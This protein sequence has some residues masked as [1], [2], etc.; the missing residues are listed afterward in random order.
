MK[1]IYNLKNT[2]CLLLLIISSLAVKS[3]TT[4]VTFGQIAS[5]T[6]QTY[7]AGTM[8]DGTT[9]R[10]SIRSNGGDAQTLTAA[11]DGY[12]TTTG[13]SKLASTSNLGS[14]LEGGK[15]YVKCTAKSGETIQLYFYA[16][17]TGSG[18]INVSDSVTSTLKSGIAFT[19]ATTK[20]LYSVT[21]TATS[22]GTFYFSSAS[23]SIY[24][25][26]IV[27]SGTTTT[28][29]LAPTPTSV[30]SLYYNT[31][32]ATDNTGGNP[33]MGQ[34]T[35]KGKN[36]TTA[37]TATITAPT[38]FQISL[39]GTGGWGTTATVSPTADSINKVIYVRIDPT[40]T[41]VGT[42]S[43]NITFSQ[44]DVASITSVA[45]S[46]QVV[47]LTPISCPGTMTVSSITYS[48]A[49]F[50][51]TNV[52]GNNGYIV[53]VYKG[54]VLVGSAQTLA[55]NT[56]TYSIAGL[57]Q[58]TAYTVTVTVIGNGS[59]SGNSVEC[60]AQSF[61]TLKAPSSNKVTCWTEDFETLSPS[62]NTNSSACPASGA[63]TNELRYNADSGT[64][65]GTS[66]CST[67]PFSLSLPSGT[68][69]NGNY[70]AA[71][72][73]GHS[74]SS[75][76]LYVRNT[77]GT[78]TFPTLDNPR[79]VTFYVY[80]KGAVTNTARGLTLYLDGSAIT[81]NIKID[82]IAYTTA[83]GLIRF[84]SAGWHK[85]SVDL[86][87]NT[88]N[89][90]S[91]AVTGDSSMDI[92]IDDVTVECSSML[93]TASPNASGMNYVVDLG[94]SSIHTFTVTGTD[95]PNASGNITLSNLGNFQLSFDNGTTWSSTSSVNLPYTSSTFAQSVM[96]R[97]AAG[98]AVADYSTTIAFSCPGYTKVAP[99]LKLSGKV[100]LL[101]N[102]LPC[103]EEVTLLNMKGTNES[104]I[105]LDAITGTNWIATSATKN[106]HFLLSKGA[107][108][109]S[110][111]ISLGEYDL[112]SVKFSFQPSN[113][114]SMTMALSCFGD[115]GSFSPVTFS[116]SQTTPYTFTQDLSTA[117]FTDNFYLTF[118]DGSQTNIEMWDI[119]VT[120]V[121]KRQI[122]L[123]TATLSGFV[124]YSID[125]PSAIQS[126]MV[127]GTCLDD[128]SS[129]NFTSSLYE[130]SEDG[131]AW[132]TADA[133][134]V[135]KLTYTGP[136]PVGGMKV[137]VRQKGTSATTGFAAS[138]VV[139]I[140]NGGA[141]S[142]ALLLSGTVTPPSDIQVPSVVNFSSLSGVASIF[143]IPIVGGVSCNPLV[144]SSNC[145]SLTLSN[146]KGGTYAATTTFAVDDS[147]RTLYLKYTPGANLNCTL[148]LTSGSFTKTI[149]LIWTG[150][151]SITNGVAIDNA[152][153]KYA[154]TNGFGTVNVWKAGSLP[155]ATTVTITSPDFDVSMGNPTYGDFVAITSAKLGDLKGILYI[156]QKTTATSGTIT[157]ATAGGQ[158]TTINVTVQ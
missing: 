153:V 4:T 64:P 55:L 138:E 72:G 156:R 142:A 106:N 24:A 144:V 52:T 66:Y 17:G 111:T 108:L 85:V 42:V 22:D 150:V 57:D 16:T 139:N 51:W 65:S 95:L 38:G 89:T 50:S 18:T 78:L 2:F 129:L 121:P 19:I 48:G 69:P 157:L 96:V 148:T 36:L 119:V 45:V 88:Q 117:G 112:K 107:S 105:L 62:A 124:S 123:S 86:T 133:N 77:S 12:I 23:S 67:G 43:G 15:Y 147:S 115:G 114:T 11:A 35:L 39:T 59:T 103:G 33:S 154:A 109:T 92:W 63:T 141:G 97:L 101:P 94:P 149:N 93:L 126:L 75:R 58:L 27:F 54:G 70:L 61:T 104:N 143:S 110:P 135:S 132:V 90:F 118:T 100:T 155:D 73:A 8:S 83:D 120:G 1:H 40:Y 151:T 34:F 7:S 131:I 26:T 53:K 21:W 137:Y 80:A 87:S 113:S 140:T 116:G 41:T 122:N 81:S 28:P 9:R 44:A 125:C 46:G 13:G 5:G 146:C 145:S 31:A 98:L 10:L 158:T 6:T 3:A 136:F 68:W 56:T 134:N 91:F 47:N 49:I 152:A 74:G 30:S 130:F 60:A 37:N 99:T 32:G 102:T 79:T 20:K 128:N 84:S 127:L 14:A 76:S 29:T 71:S 25:T 82:D